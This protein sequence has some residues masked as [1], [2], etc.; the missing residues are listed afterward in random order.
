MD[1]HNVP[2]E[3]ILRFELIRHLLGHGCFISEHEM[4]CI[5]DVRGGDYGGHLEPA[6]GTADEAALHRC[7]HD[8]NW[9]RMAY[10]YEATLARES[11]QD[12]DDGGGMGCSY[13]HLIYVDQGRRPM[14][15]HQT[16]TANTVIVATQ[17]VITGWSWTRSE[18]GGVQLN[19]GPPPDWL[20]PWLTREPHAV[21]FAEQERRARQDALEAE[22]IDKAGPWDVA[23]LDDY[24]LVDSSTVLE[25]GR[26]W[27]E[28]REGLEA[29]YFGAPPEPIRLRFFV[30]PCD[31]CGL[32][33]RGE[34]VNCPTDPDPF[35]A[36]YQYA[37]EQGA[38]IRT[39]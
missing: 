22:I 34:H 30:R 3:T 37:V 9:A 28:L 26:G 4:M 38:T 7:D 15:V 2:T 14:L 25:W 23:L 31:R 12:V 16:C 24:T 29:Q 27:L 5:R 8:R 21:G 11:Q 32:P 33:L 39:V 19:F 35:W 13:P 1:M 10:R 17:D 6:E 18:I 20:Q 36:A